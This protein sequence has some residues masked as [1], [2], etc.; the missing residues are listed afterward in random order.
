MTINEV[1]RAIRKRWWIVALV[2]VLSGAGASYMTSRQVQKYQSSV[3]FFVSTP[4]T[5]DVTAL[6][7]DQFAARRVNSYVRLLKSDVLAAEI[8]SAGVDLPVGR[9]AAE[10]HGSADLNTVLLTA[11]VQDASKARALRIAQLIAERFESVVSRLDAQA[12]PTKIDGKNYAV[13]LKVSSGPSVLAGPIYPHK[14]LNLAIGIGFGLVL[15]ILLV[16]LRELTDTSVGSVDELHSVT[17]APPLGSVPFDRTARRAPLLLDGR[18]NPVRA[19]SFRKIRTGLQFASVDEPIQVLAVSSSLPGEGKTSTAMNLAV[20]TAEAGKRVLIIDCDMRRPRIA[21]YTG[22]TGAV[23]LTDVLAGRAEFRHVVQSWGEHGLD[24]LVCGFLPPNPSELLSSRAMAELVA[25]LREHYDLIVL[26]TPPLVPVT[27]AAVTASFS[28]GMVLVVRQRKTSRAN[29]KSAIR[30]LQAVN[31]RILGTV[32]TMVRGHGTDDGYTTY[33]TSYTQR[34]L[35]RWRG[36]FRRRTPKIIE[37]VEDGRAAKTLNQSRQVRS[38]RA[39]RG[40]SAER[41]SG[42]VSSRSASSSR[43]GEPA[44]PDSSDPD[45]ARSRRGSRSGASSR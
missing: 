5:N 13:Q 38:T 6:A 11:T 36:L 17:G 40:R 24:V 29:V 23:G 19:E 3:T 41:A 43:S 15:G 42:A 16:W 8:H 2:V 1:L 44:D 31:A 32:L 20:V 21:Q 12:Q 30:S 7:A 9:I 18:R 28:D 22:L 33:A 27:D 39:A 34:E 26:D 35:P 14:T 10:I 4:S 37:P 25:G 45:P